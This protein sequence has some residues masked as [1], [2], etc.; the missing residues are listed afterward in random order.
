MPLDLG[1]SDS[2]SS[3]YAAIEQERPRPGASLGTALWCA[4]QGWPVHPLAPGRKTPAANCDTCRNQPHSAQACPCI[5]AGRWCHGFHAATTDPS[6]IAAWWTEQPRFGVGVACGP[7]NLVVIDVDAHRAPLPDP[8]RLLPGIHIPTSVSLGGL[9]H[10]FHSLALL[11]ALRGAQDPSQDA[12]TLR[13]RTPSG[14]CTCGTRRG[15]AMSGAVPADRVPGGHWRGR[16]MSGRT[17]AT[18]SLPAPRPPSARTPSA[19][20][21]GTPRRCRAGSPPNLSAP[22]TARPR[23][24]RE[25]RHLYPHGPV[26]RSS[27]RAAAA[28]QRSAAWPPC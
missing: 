24:P 27:P 3:R 17:A 14:G 15:P 28:T 16:S 12:S 5:A 20:P 11:A 4:E 26:P 2:D 9:Q 10:G 19:G 8:D 23:R 22:A 1:I 21:S 18:S 25:R 7:A 13:V 6:R